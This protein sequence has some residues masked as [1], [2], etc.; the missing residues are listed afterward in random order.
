MRIEDVYTLLF[1][2]HVIFAEN[3]TLFICAGIIMFMFPER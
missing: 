3:D 2:F 1:I